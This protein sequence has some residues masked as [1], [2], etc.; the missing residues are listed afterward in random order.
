MSTGL[1]WPTSGLDQMYGGRKSSMIYYQ[2]PSTSRSTWHPTF[3][4]EVDTP[5]TSETRKNMNALSTDVLGESGLS[6]QVQSRVLEF[7]RLVSTE[8][9]TF[10]SVVPDDDGVAV[11][12]WVAG[13]RVLQV[14]V[15]DSGPTYL[16]AKEPNHQNVILTDPASI[17]PCAKIKLE[18]IAIQ[19]MA[20]NPSWRDR[21]RLR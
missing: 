5:V 4:G 13:G 20:V 11:L 12:H 14:D 10:P 21:M 9:T 7:L 8:T 17:I 2:M 19:V 3:T 6:R 16:W 15:E 1:E 18:R